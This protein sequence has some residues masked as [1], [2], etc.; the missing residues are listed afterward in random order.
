V[1]TPEDLIH[2][3]YL[4]CNS[5]T[6]AFEGVELGIGEALLKKAIVEA[7]GRSRDAI[8]CMY[9]EKGDLGIVALES[10]K[11][12]PTL[13]GFKPPALSLAD[14][15]GNFLK[16]AK[17]AG[18]KSQETKVGLIKKMLGACSGAEAKYIVRGLQGKLRIGLAEQSVLVA[19]AHAVCLTPP[20]EPE[21]TDLRAVLKNDAVTAARLDDAVKLIKQ[22]YSECP[23]YDAMVP[24][25][26]QHPLAQLKA[27]CH[28][29]AG[30]PLKPM[31][32]KPTKG[33]SEVL[34]RFSGGRFTCEFKYDGE[35]AQIHLLDNGT[36]KVF[37]RN[38]EDNST[39]YPDVV[40][41]LAQAASP[42]TKSFILDSEVVAYSRDTKRMLPFQILST[43]ARKDVASADA[44]KVQVIVCAFDLLYLNGESLL[45]TPLAKRRELLREAF[46]EVPDAFSFAV[47]RDLTDPEEILGFLH[48]AV[49]SSCEG[50]MVKTLDENATYEPS[51]RSLN[52]LKVKKDYMD[53]LTDSLDLVVVGAFNGRGKRT[54]VFGAFLLACYD[55]EA[56]EYQTV[57][58]IGTGFSEKDLEEHSARLRAMP[59]MPGKPKNVLSDMECDVWFDRAF[60]SAPPPLPPSPPPPPINANQRRSPFG[61]GGARRRLEHF[62]RAQGGA[63]AHQGRPR[64]CAPLP[65]VSARARRQG[66]RRRHNERASSAHVPKAGRDWRW[67]WWWWQRRRRRRRRRLKGR[68]GSSVLFNN[69][70]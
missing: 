46:V 44:V 26:L 32:A 1:T 70:R 39:K 4:C 6:P 38:S 17:T 13:F 45:T 65:A 25:L 50:L 27:A 11:S 62:A 33:V 54:G 36:V 24:A 52:W 69:I 61:V 63:R 20:T 3:V 16:I 64:H 14:V 40:R 2:A 35:R 55:A 23:T 15:R 56:E 68:E 41:A 8:E 7:T 67:W 22:V 59:L 47:G 5:V 37:S 58:K 48:E 43:R 28:I 30:V 53:G 19:L 21:V 60:F 49:A 29:T 51:K 18:N 12:Q 66:V 31:L 57:C 42:S 10:R 9:K 34:D